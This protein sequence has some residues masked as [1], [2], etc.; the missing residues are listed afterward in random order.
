MAEKPARTGPGVCGP[1][2]TQTAWMEKAD[3]GIDFQCPAA[4]GHGSGHSTKNLE[5]G[6]V[7]G[8]FIKLKTKKGKYKR[9]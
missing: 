1:G 4:S 3:P 2:K 8:F 9:K 7:P 6:P 5:P